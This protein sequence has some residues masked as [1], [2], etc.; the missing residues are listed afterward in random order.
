MAGRLPFTLAVSQSTHIFHVQQTVNSPSYSLQGYLASPDT[1]NHQTLIRCLASPC[2]A[3]CPPP[4]S[5]G[6][7]GKDLVRLPLAKACPLSDGVMA[8]AGV[9]QKEKMMGRG[10]RGETSLGERKYHEG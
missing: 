3:L 4:K 2:C 6:E 5:L 10:R 8:G 7:E 9:G 1:D